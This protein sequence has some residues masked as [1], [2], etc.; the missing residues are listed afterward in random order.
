MAGETFANVLAVEVAGRPLPQDVAA[1]LVSGYVDDSVRLPD[2]FVLRFRDPD[3]QVLAKAGV[4]IGSALKIYAT[5]ADDPQRQLLV[6]GEV[7]ALEVDLDTTGT[8]TVVR[9]F[10]HSHRLLRGR[11]V[12]AFR[13]AT[14]SDV[15]TQVARAAGLTV[16]EVD[17]TTTVYEHL[18]QPGISDWEFLHLLADLA[19]AEVSVVDG[20]F[21]FGVPTRAARAPSP[22]TR[23]EASPYVL[24]FGRNLL[25]CQVAVTAADQVARV[26]VRG[27]DDRTKSEIVVSEPAGSSDRLTLGLTPAQITQ[28]FGDAVHLVTGTPYPS[29]AAAAQ[30]ARTIAGDLAGSFAELDA[31]AMGIP[32]LRAGTAVTLANVGAPFEGKYTVS[33]SRHVFD[34]DT[35]YQTWVTVGG[36][37]NRSL[38]GLASGGTRAAAGGGAGAADRLCGLVNAV[39][40]D[41]RDPEDRGRLKVS[42]PWLDKEYV[43]DWA[44]ATGMGGAGGGGMFGPEVGDEV[45]VGFEQGRVDR[46]FVLGG[47]YNGQDKPSDHDV[48]LVDSTSGTVNRRSLVD[49]SGD[50]LELLDAAGGGPQGV[51]LSTGDG[52]VTLHLDR[53]DTKVVLHSDGTVEIDAKEKVT[54]KAQQ[55]VSLDAGTGKLELTGDSVSVTARTGVQLDGG[56]GAL[57]LTTNGQVAVK[58][59]T[60]GVEGTA[61]TE[62]KGGAMCAISATLVKIN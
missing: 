10:D 8:F 57:Q 41:N 33:S 24:E 28:P 51:R 13:Q 30:A 22:S 21:R 47:L 37:E 35:G 11:R 38:Y 62:I 16:G 20:T 58:G 61:N 48:P 4:R 6:S 23:P 31:V 60:V 56:T 12:K 1:L 17:A 19:G 18:A 53:K 59:T 25:R 39:V 34:P 54:V 5:A 36:R 32:K 50:R 43:S 2:M 44:R 9:G 55:G 29:Q 49:R 46:P 7:T 40:S 42:F 15:A 52:K 26:E 3:H 14:A 45:L 27:W